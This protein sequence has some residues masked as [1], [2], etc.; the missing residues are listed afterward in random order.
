MRLR[1][2]VFISQFSGKEFCTVTPQSRPIEPDG[3]SV[4]NIK[5]K[6][7]VYEKRIFARSEKTSRVR[8]NQWLCSAF[9]MDEVGNLAEALQHARDLPTGGTGIKIA[10]VLGDDT[11]L[12]GS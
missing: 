9:P 12:F 11:L 5:Y 3:F 8:S 6:E 1:T 2:N 7:G 4:G 10:A